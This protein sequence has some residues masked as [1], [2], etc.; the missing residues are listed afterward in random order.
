MGIDQEEQ[1]VQEILKENIS[2]PSVGTVKP[3]DIQKRVIFMSGNT[4]LT[5]KQFLNYYAVQVSELV[6]DPNIYFN[7]S[8]DNG[9]AAMLQQVFDRLLEDK[10]RVNVFHMGNAPKNI[11]ANFVLIGGFT[12][13]EERDAGMTLSSNLDYHVVLS[14]KGR[15]LVERNICRRNS[16]EYDFNQHWL[17]GNRQFW[18]LFKK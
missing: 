1:E 11:A 12:S 7:I 2:D 9:C 15:T 10:T 5:E 16:P 14:G 3:E 17:M 18:N 13:L 4:D 8:D 6:K